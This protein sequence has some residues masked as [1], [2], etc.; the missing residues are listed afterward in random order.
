M[1]PADTAAYNDD[2]I[3]A[4]DVTLYTEDGPLPT[5]CYSALFEDPA[6]P[7]QTP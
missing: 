2:D 6:H 3:V 5:Q 1:T 7:Q 4:F